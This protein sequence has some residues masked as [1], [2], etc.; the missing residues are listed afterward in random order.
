MYKV[1]FYEDKSGHSEIWDFLEELR[2]KSSTNKT[3]RIEFNQISLYIDL[4][5]K[6]G[7]RAG[8][9]I[10]KNIEGDLWELRPGKNRILFFYWRDNQFVLLHQFRKKTMKTPKREIEKAKAFMKD[11]RKRNENME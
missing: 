6:L 1:I 4:L 5:E 2:L 11:W 3:A 8:E 10:T 9:K 7:T